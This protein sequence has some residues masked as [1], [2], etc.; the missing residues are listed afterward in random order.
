L[1]DI[2]FTLHQGEILGIAGLVACGMHI[3]GRALF[4][5]IPFKGR[6]A[7]QG[8]SYDSLTP[9]Q[10]IDLG[11]GF[12]PRERDKEGLILVHSLSD[13]IA[14]PSLQKL[15]PERLPVLVSDKKKGELSDRYR[16]ELLI[17]APSVKTICYALS[18]GN[19]QKVVLGKWLARSV[20]ILIMACPTRGIDVG[21]KAEIY[22]FMESLRKKGRGIIMISE[23]LPELLGMSDRILVMKEGRITWSVMRAESPT[24]EAI[25]SHMM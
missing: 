7:V 1:R 21:A 25:V 8:R 14:L 17:R 20:S 3:L 19:R 18:G 22:H 9:Q 23:E 5:I 4:G 2:S 6:I 13:N 16:K 11:I 12:V 24:E 10:A 15:V